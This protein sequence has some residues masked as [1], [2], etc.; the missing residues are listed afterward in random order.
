MNCYDVYK[1]TQNRYSQN[2]AVT[3]EQQNQLLNL[4]K[5]DWLDSL[6]MLK[7]ATTE[8]KELKLQ[9]KLSTMMC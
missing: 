4:L 1:S 3:D 5:T 2:N 7:Q 6:E 9:K 8:L